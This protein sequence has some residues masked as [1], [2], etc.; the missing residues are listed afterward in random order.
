MWKCKQNPH[1]PPQFAF[2]HGGFF[3]LVGW[4]GE[5]VV[6][7]VCLFVFHSNRNPKKDRNLD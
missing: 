3:C 4:L 2:G 1:F 7:V 6:V 5:W